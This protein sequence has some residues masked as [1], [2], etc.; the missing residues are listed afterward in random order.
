M[1]K[2]SLSLAIL[3]SF[4]VIVF[5]MQPLTQM[6]TVKANPFGDPFILIDS[7]DAY[8]QD[9]YQ[10]T[11]IPIEVILTPLRQIENL[12]IYTIA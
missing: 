4:L 2:I 7:P 12:G 6:A 1:Q 5:L 9:I 8:P 10:T 11:S 3:T